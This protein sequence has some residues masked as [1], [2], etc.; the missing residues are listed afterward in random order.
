MMTALY[1]VV[2][3]KLSKSQRIPQASHATA[4][5]MHEYGSDPEVVD[6]VREDR[7]MVCLKADSERLADVMNS[8]H[9][10]AD[11][12]DEDLADMRTAVAIGPLDRQTG[13]RLF[14]DLSLA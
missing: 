8:E 5:F 10:T 4:E 6:W 11:F 3:E 2:D 13:Q 7:T 9:R 14:G 1:I 12:V